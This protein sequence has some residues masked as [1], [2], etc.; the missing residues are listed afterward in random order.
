MM[1]YRYSGDRL[2]APELKNMYCDPVRRADG[3]CITGGSKI[4]VVDRTGQQF[5]VLRNRLRI[6]MA[7]QL[8]LFS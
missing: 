5:V 2:T 8:E 1:R 6:Q 3:K 4:L 7:E